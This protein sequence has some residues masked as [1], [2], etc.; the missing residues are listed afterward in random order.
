MGFG[1][2]ANKDCDVL[3]LAPRPAEKPIKQIKLEA[4]IAL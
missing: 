2:Y 4:N 3:F 1:M